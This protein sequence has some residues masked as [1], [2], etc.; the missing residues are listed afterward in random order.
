MKHRIEKRTARPRRARQC[1]ARGVAACSPGAFARAS[2]SHHN[3]LSAG[4][5]RA[6]Q[7]PARRERA[8]REGRRS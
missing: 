6:H 1:V 5:R 4:E 2:G 7:A 8:L 3:D